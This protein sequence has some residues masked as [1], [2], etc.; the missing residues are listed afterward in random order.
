MRLLCYGVSVFL[1][2]VSLLSSVHELI[3]M[4]S[5]FLLFV[6][7]IFVPICL[8]GYVA[9]HVALKHKLDD[10][11]KY[12]LLIPAT[13][14]MIY[15][16]AAVDWYWIAILYILGWIFLEKCK[17]NIFDQLGCM[18]FLVSL[19]YW[20]WNYWFN[21]QLPSA[22]EVFAIVFLACTLISIGTEYQLGKL[23]GLN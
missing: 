8:I 7:P 2:A 5:W 9:T 20:A 12:L 4:L 19:N 11:T 17:L 21:K 1:I 16:I 22:L 18:M 13:A 15:F 23:K 3:G 14:V 6:V 10:Q